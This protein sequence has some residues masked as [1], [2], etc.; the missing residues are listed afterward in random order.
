MAY[1]SLDTGVWEVYVRSWPAGDLV[2]QISTTGGLEPRW[3]PCGE[4]FYRAGDIFWSVEIQT[5]PKLVWQSPQVAFETD[6][7]DTP[8][9][10][11]DISSDG[12]RLYVV[13]QAKPDVADRVHVVFDW[14]AELNRLVT[15]N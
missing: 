5:D 12:S 15:A 8:G 6:F 4:L 7:I 3:C 2:R 11:F 13:K 9:L 1:A 14:L 10:S